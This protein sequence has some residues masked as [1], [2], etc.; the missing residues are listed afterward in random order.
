M[1]NFMI[2]AKVTGLIIMIVVYI[3]TVVFLYFRRK[4]Q[5]ILNRSPFL[6]ITSIFLSFFTLMS[7]FMILFLP[8]GNSGK[9][10]D[11][12]IRI[13]YHC[14]TF[15]YNIN[16]NIFNFLI[17]YLLRAL[18][19]NQIYQYNSKEN[20]NYMKEKI[21]MKFFIVIFSIISLMFIVLH[22]LKKVN[23]ILF[24]SIPQCQHKIRDEIKEARFWLQIIIS[25]IK[26][27]MIL[28]SSYLVYD[29]NDQFY[30]SSEILYVSWIFL[31]LE[32]FKIIFNI[33]E[34]LPQYISNI[35]I[36]FFQTFTVLV[37]SGIFVIYKSYE[38]GKIPV[39]YTVESIKN[40]NLLMY[41]EKALKVFFKFIQKRNK[42]SSL[43]LISL[44]KLERKLKNLDDLGL[45]EK[46]EY[47]YIESFNKNSEIDILTK[48]F[49]NKEYFDLFSDDFEQKI[50]NKEVSIESLYQIKNSILNHLN[51]EYFEKFKADDDY[52]KLKNDLEIEEIIYD[53]LSRAKDIDFNLTDNEFD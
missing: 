40:F 38:K 33:T 6:T 4:S 30:I 41:N 12:E 42:K 46:D 27:V 22:N 51:E 53:R 9:K 50:K 14:W 8:S 13:S 44:F 2:G 45:I 17:C 16:V 35:G 21:F 29:I 49:A 11:E 31:L 26:I 5:I 20:K 47:Y 34:I 37:I 43:M 32:F 24:D 48:S 15:N 28:Y 19:L 52:I 3:I 39:C 25:S 1:T 10:Y 23:V 36:L 7:I 18:R